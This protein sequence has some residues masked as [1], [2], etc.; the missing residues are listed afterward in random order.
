MVSK[1][2]LGVGMKKKNFLVLVIGVFFSLTAIADVVKPAFP[3]YASCTVTNGVIDATC[4]SNI[5]AKYKFDLSVF[6]QQVYMTSTGS[7]N[8]TSAPVPPV[9]NCA[10]NSDGTLNNGCEISYKNQYQTYNSNLQTYTALQQQ[11]SDTQQAQQA[12]L[13]AR[14]TSVSTGTTGSATGTLADITEKNKSGSKIYQ[15][16]AI[17]CTGAAIFYGSQFAASCAGAG[18][19]CKYDLLYKSLAFAAFAALASS[20]AK[21][22]DDSAAASCLSLNQLSSTPNPACTGSSAPG[23]TPIIDPATTISGFPTQLDPVTGACKASAPASCTTLRQDAIDKGVDLKALAKNA[24][25]FSGDKAPFKINPDG[26]VTTKDGK[27][28]TAADFKDEKAMIAAGLTSADAASLSNELNGAGGVLAKAGL[29]AKG[30]L[31]DLNSGT[32]GKKDFGAFGSLSGGNSAS[33]DSNKSDPTSG[34]L[35]SKDDLTGS[36]AG[37][38]PSSANTGLVRNFH[39]DSIGIS[40]DDIFKMMNKRYKLKSAQDAFINP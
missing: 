10:H 12:A 25:M 5:D 21:S 35:G 9:Y 4:K 32:P 31:K 16:A 13:Q 18:A 40:N 30:D 22:H 8:G 20:Q 29:D 27:T 19:T 17:G 11:V 6:N 7:Y 14:V 39:G 1:S 3:G 15:I 36:A 37:R 33:L 28:F 23:T 24:N 2:F 38:K 34:A 26:S